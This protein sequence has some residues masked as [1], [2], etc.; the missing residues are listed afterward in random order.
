MAWR[1]VIGY[2]GSEAAEDAVAFGLTWCRST[3]DV[4]VVAT[5]YPEEHPLG[6]GRVD[7]EWAA[8]VRELGQETL[9]KA[10]AAAGDAAI[11][12]LVA[13]TS[14]TRGLADLAEDVDAAAVLV[15]GGRKAE[16]GRRRIGSVANRLLYGATVPVCVVPEAWQA[17]DSDLISK[18]GVAFVDTKDGHEA[19]RAAVRAASR[20][21]ARLVLYSVVA[22]STEHYSFIA[23]RRDEQVFYDAAR[24]SY[25]QALDYAVAGVPPQL[26]PQAVL[27]EGDVAERLAEL[28]LDDLDMLVCGSRGYGPIRR[29]LLGGVSAR[30]VRRSQL[31][32]MVVPRASAGSSATQD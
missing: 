5:V 10:Q 26:E 13:S 31:P 4:P 17:P 6:A 14:A 30:L 7:A 15:G 28:G 12:R 2:D 20:I 18:I 9:D 32:V 22:R 19:L 16:G 24:A 1:V 27:L 23:G 3:G 25:T 21:P 11:Y 29:V 8:Y